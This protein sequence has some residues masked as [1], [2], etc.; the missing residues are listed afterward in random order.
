MEGI[1]KEKIIY[2]E[3]YKKWGA[4]LRDDRLPALNHL[5]DGFKVSEAYIEKAGISERDGEKQEFQI[6]RVYFKEAN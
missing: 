6:I 4:K 5:N 2:E 1:M 3:G